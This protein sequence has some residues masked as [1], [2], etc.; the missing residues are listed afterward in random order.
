MGLTQEGSKL[1]VV[2]ETSTSSYTSTAFTDPVIIEFESETGKLKRGKFLS[3][4]SNV[5][6]GRNLSKAVNGPFLF[7]GASKGSYGHNY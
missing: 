2:L 7:A 5:R 4:L 3:L 1:F 6:L